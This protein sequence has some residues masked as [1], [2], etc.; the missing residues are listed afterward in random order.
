MF[1]LFTAI[2]L[3]DAV[4]RYETEGS[5]FIEQNR[6]ALKSGP[7]NVMEMWSDYVHGMDIVG[8]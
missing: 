8:S 5:K 6:D 4:L 1:V 2:L 3:I 7:N